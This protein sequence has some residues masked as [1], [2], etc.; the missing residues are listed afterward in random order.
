MHTAERFGNEIGSGAETEPGADEVRS[1]LEQILASQ[2]FRT[3]R[4]CQNLLHYIVDR[5]LKGEDSSLRER[6]LGVEVFGR[7]TD[8]DT[9]EDPVVRMRAADVRKRLA[10]FYQA[11]DPQLLHIEIKPGSYRAAFRYTHPHD[12]EPAPAPRSDLLPAPPPATPPTSVESTQLLSAPTSVQSIPLQQISRPQA[13]PSAERSQSHSHRRNILLGSIAALLLAIAALAIAG[14]HLWA[15]RSTRAQQRFW[16]PLLQSRQ[17]ILLYL[18][19]NAAYRFTPGYLT[20]YQQEHSLP[21]QNGPEFFP[22]LPPG[23]SIRSEDLLPQQGT[24]VTVGDLAASVQVVT[25]LNNWSRPF[26]LRAA[27]DVSMSDVRNAPAIF[28]GGFN[29]RWSLSATDQ[30][31]LSFRDGTS[32][33]DRQ[34]SGRQWSIDPNIHAETMEDYAL[35]SRVLHSKTGGPILE[36]GGIG[37]FG[38]QAAAEFVCSPEKMNELLSAAPKGWTGDNVQA[39]LHIQVVGYAPVKVDI[40][41]TVFW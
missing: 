33:V 4:Q 1:A 31:P 19:A 20:R 35:V 34:A 30:L 6:I 17:P 11:A 14:S 7:P 16:A 24:F 10:Q 25:L 37:S 13:V 8:Y 40:V 38:T 29:N 2:P 18:G 12:L 28:V 27:E 39:V 23:A 26:L 21:Q 36:I 5:S 9:A 32:I 22:T 3:S 41:K 15:G